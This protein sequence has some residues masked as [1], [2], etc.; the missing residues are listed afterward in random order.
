MK[1]GFNKQIK[2]A[3][4]FLF[5]LYRKWNEWGILGP[6]FFFNFSL[7]VNCFFSE[8]VPNGKYLKED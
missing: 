6:T 5:L 4:H 2:V 3:A 1:L 7:Y 8:K